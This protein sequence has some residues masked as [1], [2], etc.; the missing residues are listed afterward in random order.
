MRKVIALLTMIVVLVAL[1]ISGCSFGIAQA[2]TAT[3]TPTRTPKPTFTPLGLETPTPEAIPTATNTP[4]VVP[5]DTPTL[6]PSPAATPT[7]TNTPIPPPTPTS[8]PPP[9]TATPTPTDT[10]TPVLPCSY[11]AG[12]KYTSAAG[13]PAEASQPCGVFEGYVVDAAGN[14]LNNYGV[15]FEHAN[16]N[17]P[18]RCVVSGDPLQNWQPGQW[19][20]DVWCAA[21]QGLG[22]KST[23]YITIKQSCDPGAPALSIKEDFVYQIWSEGHV[24]NMMFVCSW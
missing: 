14:G 6:A 17:P 4:V 8:P 13:K 16:A 10:P 21:G 23:Y 2:P 1:G 22:V 9:P 24:H 7:A 3:P 11:V 19:K 12:S 20:H 15:Y 5:T 18:T